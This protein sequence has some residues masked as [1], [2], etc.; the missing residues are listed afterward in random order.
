MQNCTT[1]VLMGLC[2]VGA[3]ACDTETPSNNT[4]QSELTLSYVSGHLGSY[5]DCPN[6]ANGASADAGPSLPEFAAD[7]DGE[8]CGAMNCESAEVTIQIKNLGPDVIQ[9]FDVLQVLLLDGSQATP[10]DSEVLSWT[11]SPADAL[12]DGLTPDEAVT[13][14]IEFRGPSSVDFQQKQEDD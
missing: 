12:E 4:S 7:C 6:E 11:L 13:V 14:R 3:L 9:G 1:R 2:L 8:G 5:W 10:T